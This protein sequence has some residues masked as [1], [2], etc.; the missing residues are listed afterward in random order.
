MASLA[1]RQNTWYEDGNEWEIKWA[2]FAAIVCGIIFLMV[3]TYGHARYRLHKGKQPYRY[4]MWLVRNRM[5]FQDS[6]R[7]RQ[8][9]RATYREDYH[10]YSAYPMTAY[11][12][13]T[14]EV[15][16]PPPAYDPRYPSPPEYCPDPKP[17]VSASSL[18][19]P[20]GAS[21]SRDYE[22]YIANHDHQSR[23]LPTATE[24]TLTNENDTQVADYAAQPPSPSPPTTSPSPNIDNGRNVS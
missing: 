4:Q 19:S 22:N 7:R 13:N 3:L 5:Q 18:D 1:K 9:D 15:V 23:L 10:E 14:A 17:D 6:Q 11:G 21:S 20:D 16:V 12:G 2:V 24:T 8:A